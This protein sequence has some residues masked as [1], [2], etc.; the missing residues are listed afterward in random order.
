MRTHDPC[1]H[2][3]VAESDSYTIDCRYNARTHLL[4]KVKKLKK[5]IETEKKERKGCGGSGKSGR[6]D[7]KGKKRTEGTR[8]IQTW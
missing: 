8:K 1:S 3:D 2:C 6:R 7:R 5:V 4:V